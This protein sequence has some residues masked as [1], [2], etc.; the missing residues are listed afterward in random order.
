MLRKITS[1][2]LLTALWAVTP[3]VLADS[4]AVSEMRSL[5]DQVQE[6]KSDV[7]SIAAELDVLEERLLFPSN[8]QVTVFVAL[9]DDQDA[10][11]DAVHLALGDSTA[12]HHIYS[13]KELEA[14]QQGGV[15]RLFMGNLPRGSHALEV[16][17]SGQRTNGKAFEYVETFSFEKGVEPT[18]LGLTL[19]PDSSSRPIALGDW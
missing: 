8:S 5:D 17:I 4:T 19:S 7:L 13:F 6:I 9:E 11:L 2:A 10:R 12:A 14:L 16:T 18:L 15:Q 3:V 1:M